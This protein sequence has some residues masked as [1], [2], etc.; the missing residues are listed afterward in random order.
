MASANHIYLHLIA[1]YKLPTMLFT[2]A[3]LVNPPRAYRYMYIVNLI[4]GTRKNLPLLTV[5]SIDDHATLSR[6]KTH[7]LPLTGP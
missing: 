7:A 5:V 3:L 4:H 6:N 2:P 1:A